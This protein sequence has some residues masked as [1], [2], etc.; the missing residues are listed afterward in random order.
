MNN[1][2]CMVIKIA[3]YVILSCSSAT[4]IDNK[5]VSTEFNFQDDPETTGYSIQV[6]YIDYSTTEHK[7]NSGQQDYEVSMPL[8]TNKQ[9]LLETEKERYL[10][11]DYNKNFYFGST[12]IKDSRYSLVEIYP[13]DR[14]SPFYYYEFPSIDDSGIIDGSSGVRA[15]QKDNLI[16]LHYGYGSNANCVK[17]FKSGTQPD[18][19]E[20][21]QIPYIYDFYIDPYHYINNDVDYLMAYA[22]YNEKLK[23]C[24]KVIDIFNDKDPGWTIDRDSVYLS[25]LNTLIFLNDEEIY[26]EYTEYEKNA[27][28]IKE[29]INF[30]TGVTIYYKEES[31]E[32][33]N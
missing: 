29:I 33:S 27:M 26:V 17:I 16:W 31:I 21:I 1:S 3:L 13:E 14:R 9:M 32:Q 24:I 18:V 2:L 23:L 30:K 8:H 7:V 15:Y 11:K 6:P 4:N 5:V 22:T 25:Q 20:E 10:L 28:L 12:V 19:S